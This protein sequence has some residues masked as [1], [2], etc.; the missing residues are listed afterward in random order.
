MGPDWRDD[1]IA[2]LDAEVKHLQ[3]DLDA[4]RAELARTQG[5]LDAHRIMLAWA[6][7]RE[8]VRL[9]ATDDD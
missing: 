2:R 5:S 8:R 9:E 6:R 1:E 7:E 3:A 4:V